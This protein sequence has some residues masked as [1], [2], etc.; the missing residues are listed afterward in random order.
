MV[1]GPIPGN[2]EAR[3]YQAPGTLAATAGKNGAPPRENHRPSG[4]ASLAPEQ[5]ADR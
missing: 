5:P 1:G 3:D 4:L 2:E